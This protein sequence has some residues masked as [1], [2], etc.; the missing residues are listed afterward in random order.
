MDFKQLKCYNAHLLTNVSAY[1]ILSVI[2]LWGSAYS[3]APNSGTKG[4][5]ILSLALKDIFVIQ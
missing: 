1:N 3:L 5:T 2:F 4:Q